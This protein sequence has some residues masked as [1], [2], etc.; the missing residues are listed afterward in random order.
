MSGTGKV[1]RMAAVSATKQQI[2]MRYSKDDGMW[3]PS[4]PAPLESGSDGVFVNKDSESPGRSGPHGVEKNV[5]MI[6]CDSDQNPF[7]SHVKRPAGGQKDN[8]LRP[9]LIL[10]LEVGFR[11]GSVS[12]ITRRLCVPRSRQ[13]TPMP[14]LQSGGLRPMSKSRQDQKIWCCCAMT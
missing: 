6:I 8:I 10:I 11:S 5:F 4:Q 14:P 3:Y 13:V 7:S 2:D 1:F 12:V 9:P